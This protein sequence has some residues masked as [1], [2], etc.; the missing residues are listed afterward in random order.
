MKNFREK[1]LLGA[2][3]KV[4]GQIGSQAI[5]LT[6]AIILAHLLT[7]RDF[8]LA[9]MVIIL[10][11][12][13]SIVASFGRAAVIQKAEVSQELLS[14]MFW[15]NVLVGMVLTSLLAASAPMVATAYKEPQLLWL[16]IAFS[17]TFLINSL[18]ITQNALLQREIDFRTFAIMDITTE[19]VA[20]ACGVAAAYMGC[21]VWSLVLQ[22]VLTSMLRAV[23]LWRQSKWR[24]DLS[25][26]WRA[27]RVI[28]DFSIHTFLADAMQYWVRNVD[29]LLIGLFLGSGPL[30]IYTRAYAVMLVPIN[31]VARVLSDVMFA[32][33]SRIQ[34][35]REYVK[36]VFLKMT[37]AV[38]LVTFPMMLGVMAVAR[39]FVHSLFGPQWSGMVP[40]LEV[41]C[42]IG[43]IQSVMMFMRNIYLTQGKASL[44]LRV[45]FP[46]QLL[47]ILGIV[48]G[49]KWGIMGVAVG[50][51]AASIFVA[52]PSLY[53]AGRMIGLGSWEYVKNLFGVLGCAAAM[54][55]SLRGLVHVLPHGI[56]SPAALAIE[57]FLGVLIYCALLHVLRIEAYED[58][59]AEVFKRFN[60]V[61]IAAKAEA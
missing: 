1:T 3:W 29:N 47:Q 21:G 42:V 52:Y 25:F 4:I 17:S 18:N 2:S 50:Y 61:S 56:A 16:T 27:V 58:V 26:Q 46:L 19:A 9:A 15:I 6:V 41:L 51:A 23:I 55:V 35:N 54:A 49:L 8:G 24:P 33:F 53:F 11:N 12:F 14:S 39:H 7:P 30:G 60:P 5:Q 32:S 37:R 34:D 59:K 10:T 28:M 20:G 31:R 36:R 13:G 38:A 44:Y 43:L 57:V 48:A 45:E 22:S 40:V